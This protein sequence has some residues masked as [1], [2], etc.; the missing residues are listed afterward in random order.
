MQEISG[1]FG[2]AIHIETL[3]TRVIAEM[4]RAK[5]GFDVVPHLSDLKSIDLFECVQTGY[6]FWRPESI[7]GSESFY[8]GLSAAWP[9]YYRDWRWEYG[10]MLSMLT[11][12]DRLLEVG[13][14]RGYFLKL[15]EGRVKAATG[16]ELNFEAIQNKVTSN[17]IHATTIEEHAR[18][19]PRAYEIACSF[20]VLEHVTNPA[21]FI[22]SC[23]AAV[24][25]GGLIAFSTP[26]LKHRAFSRRQ[27]AFDLPPHHVGYFTPDVYRRLAKTYGLK[28]ESITEESRW[29]TTGAGLKATA[30]RWLVRV[31]QSLLGPGACVLAV[32]R[33]S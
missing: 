19:H 6:R 5:C 30:R 14:G 13:S 8:R 9:E 24:R 4:Y 15:T 10:P 16:L 22:E 18:A 28:L 1:P 3:P 20:Q 33:R 2:R 17:S 12:S 29:D 21:S 31:R 32:F 27:D 23:I 25:P 11:M 26:N 7:A